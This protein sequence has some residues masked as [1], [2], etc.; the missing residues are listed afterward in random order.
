MKM[1]LYLWDKIIE[2]CWSA[3]TSLHR[4]GNLPT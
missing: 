1:N 4:V 3:R 2:E